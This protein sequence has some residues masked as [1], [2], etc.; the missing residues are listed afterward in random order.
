MSA[1]ITFSHFTVHVFINHDPSIASVY[2]PD[3]F[4]DFPDLAW[5]LPQEYATPPRPEIPDILIDP[6]KGLGRHI[7]HQPFPNS[8]TLRE[9]FE[10]LES[11]FDL[12]RKFI[13]R[14]TI[15]PQHYPEVGTYPEWHDK[16]LPWNMT[17]A[18]V[19]MLDHDAVTTGQYAGVAD[20]YTPVLHLVAET[21][22]ATLKRILGGISGKNFLAHVLGEPYPYQGD[23]WNRLE[24]FINC[25]GNSS[26]PEIVL[27]LW[28][29]RSA[30]YSLQYLKNEREKLIV[31]DP[32]DRGALQSLTSKIEEFRNKKAEAKQSIS[33]LASQ[34]ENW[35]LKQSYSTDDG[36]DNGE[37]GD[38]EVE[39]I[40][41]AVLGQRRVVEQWGRSGKREPLRGMLRKAWSHGRGSTMQEQPRVDALQPETSDAKTD[42]SEEPRQMISKEEVSEQASLQGSPDTGVVKTIPFRSSDGALCPEDAK[43][44]VKSG[45]LSW[46]Q[47]LPIHYSSIQDNLTNN[48]GGVP[49][50]LPGGTI[51]Q[52]VYTYKSAARVGDWK[53]RQYYSNWRATDPWDPDGEKQP[54]GWVVCHDDIHPLEVLKKVRAINLGY[55]AISNGNGHTDKVSIGNY[56]QLTIDFS[57][58]LHEGCVVYR[59]V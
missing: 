41:R 59:K 4:S 29:W 34:W 9:L 56:H 30:L 51:K 18:E 12:D 14:F 36:S 3:F 11:E 43:F 6:R 25:Y 15:F 49:N 26:V 8:T 19:A 2:L 58:I 53:V 13:A 57:L 54:A 47:I 28:Q 55:Q 5:R 35:V 46:G 44:T 33:V 45:I 7:F 16:P 37:L 52:H 22:A 39:E 32:V 10:G 21:K 1:P 42:R 31:K 38:N 40:V 48:A 50:L 27:M 23:I 24:A 17:L 20:Q